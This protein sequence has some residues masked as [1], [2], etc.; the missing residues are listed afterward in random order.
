MDVGIYIKEK[1][2]NKI[3]KKKIIKTNYKKKTLYNG[4]EKKSKEGPFL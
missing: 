2:N 3:K 1:L 4:Q